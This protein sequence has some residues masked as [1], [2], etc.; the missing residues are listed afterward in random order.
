MTVKLNKWGNSLGLRLPNSIVKALGLETGTEVQVKL[1]NESV[2]MKPLKSHITLEWLCEGMDADNM[3]KEHFSD[4]AG[5]EKF[6][7]KE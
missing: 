7:E 2:V 1:E 5:D 3:H 4:F 6:W